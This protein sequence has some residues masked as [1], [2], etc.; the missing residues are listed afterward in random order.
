MFLRHQFK[1]YTL[2]YSPYVINLKSTTSNLLLFLRHHAPGMQEHM[3]LHTRQSAIQNSMY[4]APA[5]QTV[6]YTE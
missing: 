1:L 2:H 4:H 6:S 5:Y 3:L